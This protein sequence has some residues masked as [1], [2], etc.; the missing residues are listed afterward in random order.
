MK[1]S[2][3][4]LSSE[5]KKKKKEVNKHSLQSVLVENDVPRIYITYKQ[6]FKSYN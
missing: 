2:T 5:L 1:V 4:D 3:L 6:F